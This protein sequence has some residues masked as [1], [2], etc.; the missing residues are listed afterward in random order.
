MTKMILALA[1]AAALLFAL[2]G[3]RAAE[4]EGDASKAGEAAKSKAGAEEPG[5]SEEGEAGKPDE[6]ESDEGVGGEE[7]PAGGGGPVALADLVKD[8]FVIRTTDFVP[9]DAVT[10][11]SGKVSSDAVIVTLQKSTST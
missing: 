6:G 5:K 1:C 7:A 9:T 4:P 11:Q 2:D 10:R 8:G 3:A